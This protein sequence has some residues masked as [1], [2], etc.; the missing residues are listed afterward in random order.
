MPDLNTFKLEGTKLVPTNRFNLEPA[1]PSASFTVAPSVKVADFKVIEHPVIHSINIRPEIILIPLDIYFPL[2]ENDTVINENSTFKDYNNPDITLFFPEIELTPN[3]NTVFYYENVLDKSGNKSGLLGYVTLKYNIKNKQVSSNQRNIALNLREA[4]LNLKV[5]G[6][7]VRING[8]INTLTKE[9]QFDLKDEAVK[10]AYFNLISQIES[11]KCNIDLFFDFKGYSKYRRNLLFARDI[12]L[13]NTKMAIK[14]DLVAPKTLSTK[15]NL[16]SSPLLVKAGPAKSMISSKSITEIQRENNI[17]T[18]I[19]AELVKSTFLL[20]VNKTV[21]YAVSKEPATSLYKT[22]DGGFIVNPFNLNEDFSQFK[23]IFVAGINFSKLS[24][25]KSMVQPNTFLLISKMYSLS[26]DL[27][28]LKP[29]ISTIF[30]AFEDGVGSSEEISKISFQFAIGPNLSEFDLAKLKIA[31]LN[32]NFIDGDTTDYFNKVQFLFPNDIEAEYEVS[33]NYFLQKSDINVDG[34]HF[35]FNLSTENLAEASIMINALNNTISQFA[36]INFKHKEIKD[37]SVIELNIEKT[38][39]EIIA[40]SIDND[41]KKIQIKNQSFSSCRLNSILLVYNQNATYFNSTFFNS[42]PQLISN[43]SKVL[44]SVV[45]NPSSA[46]GN[47]EN[48]FFDF[49]NI[50][51][52]SSEFNQIVSQST[53]YNRYIQIE[54]KKQ[55][56]A[57]SKITVELTVLESGSK[58]SIERL[59]SEFSTPI[60]FNFIVKNTGINSTLISYKTNYFDKNDNLVKS[61]NEVFDFSTSSKITIIK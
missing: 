15:A 50:E 20:K 59:K 22:A 31:L 8:V 38:I 23:Q 9:I 4:I 42:Y 55:A 13:I 2:I 34:K 33:G 44:D 19:Q 54:I 32:N 57:T 36:N 26:K 28:T 14:S 1:K 61:K 51:N 37:T 49:E 43:D 39:G 48:V 27:D 52:I 12:S 60:L 40:A 11:A 58:F 29:C 6:D 18:S 47:L 3:N 30:H 25:Y 16:I 7:L 21:G 56:A 45:L 10:I 53:D 5:N 17:D 35:L 41:L 24:I 46:S